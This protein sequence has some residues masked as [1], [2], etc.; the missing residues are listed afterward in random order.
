MTDFK[1][2]GKGRYQTI[3][4]DIAV[5]DQIADGAVPYR[6]KINGKP[7]RYEWM[8][9]GRLYPDATTG[10]DLTGV[11]IPEPVELAASVPIP[12]AKANAIDW[13]KVPVPYFAKTRDGRKAV[14]FEND[15]ELTGCL[16]NMGSEQYVWFSDGKYSK[17][18]ESAVDLIGLW[19]EP[20][21][22]TLVL[23]VFLTPSETPIFVVSDD[24]A[25]AKKSEAEFITSRLIARV[26]I[27]WTEGDGLA[28]GK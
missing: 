9:N 12:E 24:E 22:G 8:A 3:A 16:T 6:G 4:G 21:K 7:R 11:R 19:I 20:R 23:S 18:A 26:P 14:I 28:E 5:I 13:C 27:K 15:G 25:E 1:Y 10:D 2:S 17:G